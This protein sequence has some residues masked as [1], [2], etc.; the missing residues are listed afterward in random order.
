MLEFRLIAQRRVIAPRRGWLVAAPVEPISS[1]QRFITL[2][3]STMMHRW[4][5]F[6]SVM[7]LPNNFVLRR[8]FRALAMHSGKRTR[9]NVLCTQFGARHHAGRPSPA[10][11]QALP[12]KGQP[13]PQHALDADSHFELPLALR[14]PSTAAS[15]QAETLKISPSRRTDECPLAACLL[16]QHVRWRKF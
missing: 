13:T 10:A 5:T 7:V 14:C 2:A 15:R 4:P 6:H 9:H 3:V 12:G 8:P 16:S 11:V 1:G